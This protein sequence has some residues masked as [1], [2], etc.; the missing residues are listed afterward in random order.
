MAEML[1]IG[2]AAALAGVTASAIRFY[3]RRGLLTPDA[4]SSGQRRY[5]TPTVRRLV[6]IRMLQDAGLALD[7][8]DGILHASTVDEWKPIAERR[9]RAL[10]GEIQQLQHAR[11]LLAGALLCRYD[12]PATEC[13]I[14]GAEIDRRLMPSLPIGGERV[15]VAGL[16][17]ESSSRPRHAVPVQYRSRSGIMRAWR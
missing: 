1:T 10:D 17:S 8:I 4:W 9:L 2:E 14:M 6:F 7:E 5:T 3:E 13:R 16:L 11:E 12:H 15:S